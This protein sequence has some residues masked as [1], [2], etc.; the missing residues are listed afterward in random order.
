MSAA[1]DIEIRIREAH[2]KCDKN[3]L[4]MRQNGPKLII[5]T[6]M[7]VVDFDGGC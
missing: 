3:A 6:L 5:I 1:S 2:Y 7:G 4:K